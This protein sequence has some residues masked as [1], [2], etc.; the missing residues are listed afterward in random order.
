MKADQTARIGTPLTP[1]ATTIV[2]LGSGELSKE[3]AI[4]FH[5]LGVEVHAADRSADAPAQQIAHVSHV[6][7]VADPQAVTSL[8]VRIQPDYIIP[9]IE[10]IAAEV[11]EA[12]ESHQIAT[13]VPSAKAAA[14]SNSRERMRRLVVEELGIPTPNYAFAHNRAEF[15]AAFEKLGFPCIAKSAHQGPDAKANININS[16]ADIDAAWTHLAGSAGGDVSGTDA[17][18]PT[19]TGAPGT[20]TALVI[21]RIVDFDM[22]ISLP[23]VRAIDHQTGKLANW[24]CEPI[25]Y[26]YGNGDYLESWQPAQLST[27]ALDNARSVAARVSNALGGRGVF[28][29]KLFVDGDTVYFSEVHARPHDTG[30]V[31][32]ATQ[33]CNQ[34]DLHARAILGLPV[35]VTLI[36]P[37]AAVA[38][39]SPV[40]AYAVSYNGL[41]KAFSVPESTVELFGK[42][43][44]RIGRRMG[45][46]LATAEDA[47][48]ALERAH[49]AASAVEISVHES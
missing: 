43:N 7:D 49:M 10:T 45:I 32:V 1:S 46:A 44:A 35:D 25:A 15:D 3:L 33:R 37:G 31:T 42:H 18:T 5:R 24:F 38:L 4:S 20:P 12:V 27:A 9:E 30:L 29:V 40:D 14:L 48:T 34:F 8:I 28:N 21:E 16:A 2:L 26:T 17:G 11:L 39:N 47:A 36:S 19:E 6:L 13:V 41:E 23:V 22:E